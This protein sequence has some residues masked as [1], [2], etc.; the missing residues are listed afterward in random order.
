MRGGAKINMVASDCSFDVDFRIPNGFTD[1]TIDRAVGEVLSRFP[2]ASA[3]RL[4]YNAPSWSAPDHEMIQLV[5][6]NAREIF[7][8]EP[9]PVVGLAG[10]D[11]RLWRYH[12]VPA[13]VFGPAPNGMGSFDEHVAEDEALNVLKVHLACAYE[14]LRAAAA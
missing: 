3:E 10:T 9:T 8:V 7:G 5:R 12:D 14:Y 6:S 1:E 13:T 4:L 11:A 2:K